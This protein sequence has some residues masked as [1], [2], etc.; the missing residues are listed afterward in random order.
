M[1]ILIILLIVH[2]KENPSKEVKTNSFISKYI[3]SE[4]NTT[5]KLF[6]SKL[7]NYILSMKLDNN[8]FNITNEYTFFSKGEHTIEVF[9]KNEL[10]SMEKLFESCIHI[11]KVDLS[12]IETR[13]VTSMAEMFYDCVQLTS[14]D[15]SKLKTSNVRNMSNLF[16][17]CF[18]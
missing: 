10:D 1:I 5:I 18:N 16:N 4:E 13:N 17:G 3:I 14:V 2:K 8:E 9:L 11:T 12:Q 7:N 6:N 15:L